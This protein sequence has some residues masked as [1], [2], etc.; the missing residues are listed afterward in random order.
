[1][2]MRSQTEHVCIDLTDGSTLEALVHT[3]NG[4]L[5]VTVGFGMIFII[6]PESVREVAHRILE[7]I[8][9]E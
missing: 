5:H 6:R 1:M 3:E 8:G 7:L 9:H 2:S 4:N